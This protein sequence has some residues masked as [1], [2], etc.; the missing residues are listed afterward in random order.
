MLPRR[1]VVEAVNSSRKGKHGLDL[2]FQ[3]VLHA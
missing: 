1:K 2:L 3:E